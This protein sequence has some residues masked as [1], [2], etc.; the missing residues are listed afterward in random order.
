MNINNLSLNFVQIPE[1]IE[2]NDIDLPIDSLSE[3]CKKTDKAV[4][5]LN[6]SD[7][8]L[9]KNV[10]EVRTSN[11]LFD[12]PFSPIPSSLSSFSTSSTLPSSTATLEDIDPGELFNEILEISKNNH[13]TILGGIPWKKIADQYNENHPLGPHI[14][15]KEL[16]YRYRRE[17]RQKVL[18]NLLNNP[19]PLRKK[20]SKNK[21]KNPKSP[22]SL[23]S[24]IT[25]ITT[26]PLFSTPSIFSLQ[27]SS[28]PFSTPLSPLQ[29]TLSPVSIPLPTT[30]LQRTLNQDPF[31]PIPSSISSNDSNHS[32]TS[33]PDISNQSFLANSSCQDFFLN[34][35]SFEDQCGGTKNYNPS[36]DNGLTLL[37]PLTPFTDLN[38]G[39][40]SPQTTLPQM[41]KDVFSF[42]STSLSES[43]SNIVANSSF[44][45]IPILDENSQNFNTDS[46]PSFDL[47]DTTTSQTLDLSSLTPLSNS[48]DLQLRP[49]HERHNNQHSNNYDELFDKVVEIL[50]KIGIYSNGRL[51]FNRI[52]EELQ[53][54]NFPSEKKFSEADLRTIFFNNKFKSRLANFNFPI[55]KVKTIRKVNRKDLSILL[56]KI[57]KIAKTIPLTSGR[58]IPWV[59]IAEEYEQQRK[60]ENPSE[61]VLSHHDLREKFDK[62]PD[63]IDKIRRSC[64]NGEKYIPI[65]RKRSG[66]KEIVCDIAKNF[67]LEDECIPW[68][69]LAEEYGKKF[70]NC[71]GDDLAKKCRNYTKCIKQNLKKSPTEVVSTV[72]NKKKKKAKKNTKKTKKPKT[73]HP[74]ISSSASSP[75][76]S[77][78]EA[79]SSTFSSTDSF[80][81]YSSFSSSSS[82]LSSSLSSFNTHSLSSSHSSP[83]S[84]P[85][86]SLLSALT[87]SFSLYSF[88]QPSFSISESVNNDSNNQTINDQFLEKI[89][90]ILK[91]IKVYS[92]EES[93]L[94]LVADELNN[95]YAFEKHLTI[96][97][98]RPILAGILPVSLPSSSSQDLE[99][100]EDNVEDILT[101]KVKILEQ[102]GVTAG[103][104]LPIIEPKESY[105]ID[106]KTLNI[107]YKRILNIAK[108]IEFEN[109]FVPWNKIAEE[110]KREGTKRNPPWKEYSRGDLRKIFN[111]NPHLYKKIRKSCKK[112]PTNKITM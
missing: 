4:K 98:L 97:E 100:N 61:K 79:S 18:K 2:L 92:D 103:K 23:N 59:K 89:I 5:N 48:D 78:S 104:K 44:S 101:Q 95:A 108:N 33:E 99:K 69:K 67:E 106:R 77:S 71:S 87:N 13:K 65:K 54:I 46:F 84:L 38:T 8:N 60:L 14:T 6:L 88:F 109:S 111:N 66:I 94:K 39:L 76:S 31:S 28:A 56:E 12:F 82:S 1:T 107:L 47:I 16:K 73:T 3:A 43:P 110:Y 21:N 58:F 81:T 53:K 72:T 19:N 37:D 64:I 41:Q 50:S 57:V 85:L 24:D 112:K 102:I 7:N 96:D 17:K 22:I 51:P 49:L 68:N 9:A 90:E 91:K 25:S 11:S 35:L 15:G 74:T 40:L 105:K 83:D 86:F 26:P 80:S 63:Y 34:D 20:K 42:T 75:L 10:S 27:S 55:L 29:R 93:T 52:A 36:A 30:L 70:T 32:K 45:E 62:F